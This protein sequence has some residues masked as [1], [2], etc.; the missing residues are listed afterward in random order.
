MATA[1]EEIEKGALNKSEVINDIKIMINRSDNDATNRMIDKLGFN[2]INNYITTHSYNSTKI[3]RKMLESAKNGDNYTSVGDVGNLLESIYRGNCV[4]KKASTEML[5]ILKSQTLKSKIPA[6]VP[7]GVVTANKTGELSSVENDAAIVF[8]EGAPY[9]LVVMSNEINNTSEARNNIK[10]ISSKVYNL[11]GTT[12]SSQGGTNANAKHK[13]AIVAG[14]GIQKHAGSYEE[15]ANRTKWYTTGTSGKTPSGE[16]WKEYQITKKVADYVEKFLAPYSSEVS[17]VQV[18]YSK[19][20]WERMQLAKDNG[21][22]SYVGIHFNSSENTSATGVSA[23]Y[24]N[25]D[26]KS[27]SF[28]DIFTK[29]VSE[30][31][32][33]K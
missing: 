26:S 28:A 29:K 14:H 7:S 30:E 13:V 32:V 10:E 20:N 3:Q 5:D 25:G 27:Q 8:K 2:K 15:V 24:R 16:T 17:V 6:G 31:R 1:Y 19:P 4:S 11:M 33:R 9:V 21:V 22:D 18:G 23:Y 12:S